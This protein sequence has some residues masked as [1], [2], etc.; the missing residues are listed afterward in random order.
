MNK[1]FEL[2]EQVKKINKIYKDKFPFELYTLMCAFASKN[3]IKY[4]MDIHQK[5]LKNKI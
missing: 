5:I 4:N 3:N 1:N 2:Y